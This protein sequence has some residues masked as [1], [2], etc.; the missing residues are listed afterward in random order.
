MQL[1]ELQTI[2]EISAFLRQWPVLWFFVAS[3]SL[4]VLYF[5]IHK[6][7]QVTILKTLNKLVLKSKVT[8][9]DP[10]LQRGVL[11][12]AVELI[13]LLVIYYVSKWFQGIEQELE[14]LIAGLI[15]WQVCLTLDRLL[16]AALDYYNSLEVSKK[17]PITSYI[18]LSK[19]LLWILGALML[20]S[21]WMGESPWVLF[22]GVG[23]VTAVLL[24]VFKDTLLSL[25]AGIQI[26]TNNLVRI[27]D[28]IEVPGFKA[29]GDVIEIGLHQVIVRNFDKTTVSIPVYKLTEGGFRNWRGMMETGARRLKRSIF[30]DQNSIIPLHPKLSEKLSDL[31]MLVNQN[32]ASLPP[33]KAFQVTN[34]ELFRNWLEAE[35]K[36]MPHLDS[37][38]TLMVRELA[39]TPYGLPVEI[40]AFTK[41]TDWLQY[42]RIQADLIDFVL[43][44]LTLFQLRVFQVQFSP[45]AAPKE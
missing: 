26:A 19:L 41:T 31:R 12:K 10:L 5:F 8:W 1:P 15:I 9:D 28:W 20:I 7:T 22:S 17:I 44:K 39:P 3:C 11:A 4:T 29:D 27:G 14:T 23:A 43:S 42:E 32:G 24:I 45:F 33:E 34:L 16:G 13:P 21:T 36:N 30:I 35:L 40:Y 2:Q 38:Q 18:Q 37:G 6:L 25:I